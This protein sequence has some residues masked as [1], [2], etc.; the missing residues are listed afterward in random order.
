MKR[1]IIYALAVLVVLLLVLLGT[2]GYVGKFT[3]PFGEDAS[4]SDKTAR[5]DSGN[6]SGDPFANLPDPDADA[7]ENGGRNGPLEGTPRDE[8]ERAHPPESVDTKR[9]GEGTETGT[10]GNENVIE[11]VWASGKPGVQDSDGNEDSIDA[12]IVSTRPKA[13][14]RRQEIN[15]G[16]RFE[17]R[18]LKA[19]AATPVIIS[20]K[21]DD[22]PQVPG[23]PYVMIGSLKWPTLDSEERRELERADRMQAV[24]Y[25]ARLPEFRF[26]VRDF[27]EPWFV[28]HMTEEMADDFGSK[29]LEVVVHSPAFQ[30]SG[31][32]ESIKPK[33]EDGAVEI[34]LELAPVFELVVDVSP[35]EAVEAG[36]RVWV[37]RQGLPYW[38]DADD[39]LYMSAKVPSSGRL[40]FMIPEHYGELTFGATGTNWHSG[41][42]RRAKGWGWKKGKLKLN[43]LLECANE[44]CDYVRGQVVEP[45]SNGIKARL[46]STHFGTVTYSDGTGNFE[47]YVPFEANAGTRQFL[48]TA[49]NRRLEVVPLE[50][51]GEPTRG[52]DGAAPHGPW[53]VTL[54]ERIPVRLDVPKEIMRDNDVIEVGATRVAMRGVLE[55][56]AEPTLVWGQQLVFFTANRDRT[57]YVGYIGIKEWASAFANYAAGLES[58]V[59]PKITS[60]AEALKKR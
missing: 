47:M 22:I 36:V 9:P 31:G 44:N 33:K 34:A 23:L 25:L 15:F 4:E 29:G 55:K 18:S 26:V 54:T 30:I 11:A 45:S 20:S 3:L 53:N 38:A 13:E 35:P 27:Q 16:S 32:F 42:P 60:L 48:V 46:E 37:E 17:G 49:P 14:D 1:P 19:H 12:F 10:K 6:D 5:G 56:D 41:L 50:N 57:V 58:D 39:S 21:I 8:T 2:A 40:H 52:V 51:R 28:L 43:V 7:G 59:S 24:V